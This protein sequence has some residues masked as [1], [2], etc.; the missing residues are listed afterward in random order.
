MAPSVM[1]FRCTNSGVRPRYA[2]SPFGT[3]RSVSILSEMHQS[4][5]RLFANTRFEAADPSETAVCTLPAPRCAKSS[6]RETAKT[7]TPTTMN[8]AHILTRVLPRRPCTPLRPESH[9]QIIIATAV[10][11]FTRRR[12]GPC[13]RRSLR[14]P[15][16]EHRLPFTRRRT[17][18]PRRPCTRRRGGLLPRCMTHQ[19]GAGRPLSR[20]TPL[21]RGRVSLR[22]W[23]AASTLRPL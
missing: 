4:V 18:E 17:G 19:S 9:P 22:V 14:R 21:L 11:R 5:T 23:L 20:C 1:E 2:E 6:A 15:I 16:E 3:P 7:T 8:A 13:P 12:I 10:P